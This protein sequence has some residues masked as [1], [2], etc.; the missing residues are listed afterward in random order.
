MGDKV[1]LTVKERKVLGKKVSQLR[2]QGLVP[3]VVYGHGFEATA[4][5]APEGVLNKAWREVGGRQPVYLTIGEGQK[6]LAMIKSANF[7]PVK[8]KLRHI[9]FHVV[10]Q[11][12]KVETEVP[13]RII[14][15]G[16]T[17]AEQHGLVVLQALEN[18]QISALPA[19]LPEALEVPSDKLVEEGD[20]ITV[21]DIVAIPGVE[22]HNEPDVIV[23]SVYTPS[24][25]A[26]QNDA[27]G[28]DEEADVEDV[29]AEQGAAEQG[30]AQGEGGEEAKA[31]NGNGGE[32]KEDKK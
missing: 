22:V 4:I 10:K 32:A 9:S 12:E 19:D 20:T 13:I 23:A 7:E 11:N 18:A 21:A 15:E 2:K 28:G 30:E 14:G 6:R 1:Y 27:A 26:A 5:E 16:E 31:E 17:V 25:L 29:E 3:G 8:R 24:A